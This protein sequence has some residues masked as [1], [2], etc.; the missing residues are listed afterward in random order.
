M[1]MSLLRFTMEGCDEK[2]LW[3]NIKMPY[4]EVNVGDKNVETYM[5]YHGLNIYLGII[6]K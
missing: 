6:V 2:S 1:G 4:K 3:R 5:E